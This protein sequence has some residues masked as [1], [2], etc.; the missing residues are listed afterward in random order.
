MGT[1]VNDR[2]LSDAAP[3]GTVRERMAA[4][5]Q[6]LAAQGLAAK[7]TTKQKVAVA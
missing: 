2:Q 7:A 4:K 3:Q 6:R 5:Q 1:G